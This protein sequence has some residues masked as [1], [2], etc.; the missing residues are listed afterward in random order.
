MSSNAQADS[1][2]ND[3]PLRAVPPTLPT[4]SGSPSA[5][6]VHYGSDLSTLF[7]ALECFL[8]RYPE[9]QF[10]D[11]C[12]QT[13]QLK[14]S[15][16]AAESPSLYSGVKAYVGGMPLDTL[17]QGNHP[18][19]IKQALLETLLNPTV[20]QARMLRTDL[21]VAKSPTLNECLRDLQYYV[22][23]SELST[24]AL[25]AR[26]ALTHVVRFAHKL[27]DAERQEFLTASQ[28]LTYKYFTDKAFC[29]AAPV[30]SIRD[31]SPIK[32]N[33]A[34]AIKS[35]RKS[36]GHFDVALESLL[37]F[38]SFELLSQEPTAAA[39][40]TYESMER[41]AH[42]QRARFAIFISECRTMQTERRELIY[43]HVNQN[44]HRFSRGDHIFLERQARFLNFI[45]NPS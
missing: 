35:D 10:I 36:V 24:D 32:K 37:L 1:A 40:E 41:R 45:A 33:A 39:G 15:T 2:P 7:L 30:E 8:N 29:L 21:G 17:S 13:L 19:K 38:H 16:V 20:L 28:Q 31:E 6:A 42:E 22:R 4:R 25:A 9:L 5:E 26:E 44:W 43:T 3:T 12:I 11:Q 23:L 14:L 27:P 18:K 34:P